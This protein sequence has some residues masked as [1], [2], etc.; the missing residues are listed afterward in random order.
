[1]DNYELSARVAELRGEVKLMKCTSPWAGGC[2]SYVPTAEINGRWTQPDAEPELCADAYRWIRP[3][4]NDMNAAMDLLRDVRHNG[5]SVIF[6]LQPRSE[7]NRCKIGKHGKFVESCTMPRA[8]CEAYIA[9]M[10]QQN[11]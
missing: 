5:K 1:M 4:A 10:E 3:Y 7:G 11:G 8:I 2:H 6:V 9:W